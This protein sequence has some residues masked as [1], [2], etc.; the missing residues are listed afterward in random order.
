M[1]PRKLEGGLWMPLLQESLTYPGPCL[2]G[3]ELR[4]GAGRWS[5]PPACLRDLIRMHLCFLQIPHCRR[6]WEHGFQFSSSLT[7]RVVHRGLGNKFI[8]STSTVDG[9]LP[10]A[11]YIFSYTIITET[12]ITER[13][14][15]KGI[16]NH[17]IW[18]VD[19]L[20]CREVK[21]LFWKLHSSFLAESGQ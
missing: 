2:Q 16:C 5:P 14:F 10:S 3:G 21:W 4:K 6:V 17:L 12:C 11:A 7:A 1:M 19:K 20:R 8:A 18:Q 13:D 15:D 9:L